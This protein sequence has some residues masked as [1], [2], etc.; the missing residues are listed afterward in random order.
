MSQGCAFSAALFPCAGETDTIDLA[1]F[2][3]KKMKPTDDN[4]AIAKAGTRRRS[5]TAPHARRLATSAAEAG[6][7]I[8]F[9]G[10]EIP[11]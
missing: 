6:D 5:W 8:A 3:G 9:D 4:V 7:T 1:T 2:E 11:S 10:A